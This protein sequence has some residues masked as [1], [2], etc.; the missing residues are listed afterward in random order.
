MARLRSADTRVLHRFATGV[1]AE[2]PPARPIE[3]VEPAPVP[4]EH[5]EIPEVLQSEDIGEL[6]FALRK[7]AA[8]QRRKA[9]R[10][11]EGAPFDEIIAGT[12]E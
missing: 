12:A 9:H 2:Q 4:P 6:A 10:P 8:F 1:V 3:G 5:L 7:T 11:A